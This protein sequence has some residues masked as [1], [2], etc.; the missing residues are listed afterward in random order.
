MMHGLGAIGYH[1]SYTYFTWRT[2]KWEIEAYLRELIEIAPGVRT[3]VLIRGELMFSLVE[4]DEGAESPIH[5]HP[6]VQMALV[7]EGA[8]ERH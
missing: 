2:A 3:R 6:E 5:D 1:Q 4:I 7:L 8:F